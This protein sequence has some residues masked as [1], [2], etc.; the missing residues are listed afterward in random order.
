MLIY[1]MLLSLFVKL[2]EFVAIMNENYIAFL[3]AHLILQKY[4]NTPDQ[5]H[6]NPQIKLSE[7]I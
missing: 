6:F 5:I 1:L 7:Q 4:Q 2:D 3:I